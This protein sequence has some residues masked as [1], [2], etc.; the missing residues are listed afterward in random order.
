MAWTSG[1][2]VI[3]VTNAEGYYAVMKNA[4]SLGVVWVWCVL[5]MGVVGAVVGV[6]GPV[7]WGLWRGYGMW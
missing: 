7:G 5:E 2:E 1:C 6:G 3:R 4:P